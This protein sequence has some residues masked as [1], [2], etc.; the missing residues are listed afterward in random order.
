[1]R[2]SSWRLEVRA[3]EISGLRALVALLTK[4]GHAPAGIHAV[5]H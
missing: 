3:G 5:L 4:K 1:M 2:A